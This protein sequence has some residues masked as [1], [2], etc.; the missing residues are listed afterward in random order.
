MSSVAYTELL[1]GFHRETDSGR[2]RRRKQFFTSLFNAVPV[3]TYTIEMAEIA[4][5]IGGEQAALGTIIPPIDLMIGATAIYSEFSLIT[6]NLRHFRMI[7]N[8]NVIPF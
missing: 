4:G 2:R 5:R 1:H 6:T 7:P 8:L 3:C